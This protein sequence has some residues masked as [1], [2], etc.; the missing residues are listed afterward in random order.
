[1]FLPKMPSGWLKSSLALLALAGMGA[2]EQTKA[3]FMGSSGGSSMGGSSM[4][5]S[6]SGSFGGGGSSG[7]SGSNS[8]GQFL[9]QQMDVTKFTNWTSS[10]DT[11]SGSRGGSSNGVGSTSILG[12][13]FKST[14]GQGMASGQSNSSSFGDPL[15]NISSG[16]G[17]AGGAGGARGG[18]TSRAGGR[19]STMG[20]MGGMGGGA[21]G[22][23]SGSG[24]GGNA[25]SF[26]GMSNSGTSRVAAYLTEPIFDVP[27]RQ[28]QAQGIVSPRAQ[29][30]IQEVLSRSPRFQGDNA[31]T[32][33]NDGP[34]VVLR[35]KVANAREKRIAESM[36]RLTPG[37][38]QVVNELEVAGSP[39]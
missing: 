4:G 5:S 39:E 2:F 18:T 20:G 7:S 30:E 6:G 13:S 21:M 19:T 35:G 3:Q 12:K 1:M 26:A 28:A 14:L 36:A 11:S 25:T 31:I 16:G 24:M 27:Q 17:M 34:A 29:A 37:V 22:R 33:S 9:N 23:T 15:Y 8:G 32:V 38:R 10:Y